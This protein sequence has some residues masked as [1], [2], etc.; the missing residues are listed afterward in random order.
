M[1]LLCVLEGLVGDQDEFEEGGAGDII[2][3]S[4]FLLC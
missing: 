4:F 1:G 2:V 3:V